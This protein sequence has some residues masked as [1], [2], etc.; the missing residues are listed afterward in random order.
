M[1][2]ATDDVVAPLAPTVCARSRAWARTPGATLSVRRTRNGRPGRPQRHLVLNTVVD[3]WGEDEA[4]AVSDV[5]FILLG[6]GGWDI[7]LVGRYNDVLHRD[8]ALW[9]FHRRAAT[10]VTEPPPGKEPT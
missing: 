9:R 10:F 8:G 1:T 3:T 7:K 2:A 4:T 6:D 5:V